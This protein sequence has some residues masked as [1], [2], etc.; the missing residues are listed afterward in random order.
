MI[1]LNFGAK[2]GRKELRHA[3][4]AVG[5]RYGHVGDRDGSVPGIMV[6]EKDAEGALALAQAMGIFCWRDGEEP[7]RRPGVRPERY[8]RKPLSP[9]DHSDPEEREAHD[10]CVKFHRHADGAPVV[11][12]HARS[13]GS[14]TYLCTRAPGHVGDHCSVDS[15][16]D[17][18]TGF[19]ARWA[20]EAD[21]IPAAKGANKCPA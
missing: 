18:V 14:T 8:D 6:G 10:N 15:K 2:S 20:N 13:P 4:S 3:L 1:R 12:C 17:D 11:F 7:P 19:R 16:P 5:I 9:Y 21:K